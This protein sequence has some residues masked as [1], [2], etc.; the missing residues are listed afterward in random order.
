MSGSTSCETTGYEPMQHTGEGGGFLEKNLDSKITR[1]VERRCQGFSRGNWYS[2][3]LT[4]ARTRRQMRF[5]E[6]LLLHR[7]G[8]NPRA[9]LESIS[10]RCYLREAAF[11][12]ELTKETICLPLGCLQGGQEYRCIPA[13][14]QRFRFT[15]PFHALP[16][17][18]SQNV[19]VN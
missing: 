5:E 18:I 12:W 7:P 1:R 15:V 16:K 4:D 2:K 8:G 11:E 10:R 6:P 14:T 3:M 13:H 19:F 9:N 17:I